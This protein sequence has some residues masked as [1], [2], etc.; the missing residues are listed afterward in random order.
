MDAT[1][2]IALSMAIAIGLSAI[3][4]GIGQGIATARATESMARQPEMAGG[5]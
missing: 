1:G 4:S 2:L 5:I 3:G